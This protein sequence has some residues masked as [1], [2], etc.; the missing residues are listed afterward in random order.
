MKK[1]L[2]IF[3]R[4]L[5]IAVAASLIG[6]GL[7]HVSSKPVPWIYAPPNEIEIS[8]LKVPLIDEKEARKLMDKEGT[9][10]VD[11]RHKDD[12][13]KKRVKGA[14]FLPQDDKEERFVLV[15]PLLPEDARL[16]FYCYGPQCDMAEE[17][18]RFLSQLGYKQMMIMTAGFRAWDQ[19]GYPI[20]GETER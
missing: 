1:S 11:T 17:V 7:N 5:L 10:F 9:I 13:D 6:L 19:A 12:Y 20:E 2:G 4:A 15:Q 3:F 14:I 16:I 18:A 8:G